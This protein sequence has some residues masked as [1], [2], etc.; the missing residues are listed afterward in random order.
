[1]EI[2][3]KR[4]VFNSK[5]RSAASVI[6]YLWLRTR[7]MTNQAA[8][9]AAYL[10]GCLSKLAHSFQEKPSLGLGLQPG[11]LWLSMPGELLLAWLCAGV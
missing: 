10:L 7:V 4:D 5:V 9:C 3:L 6:V 1:M 8:D 2:T 11:G